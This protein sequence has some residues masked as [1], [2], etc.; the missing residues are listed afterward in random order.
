[1]QQLTE[2]PKFDTLKNRSEVTHEEFQKQK[3]TFASQQVCG[4]VCLPVCQL[5]LEQRMGQTRNNLFS[6]YIS[7]YDSQIADLLLAM[8]SFLCPVGFNQCT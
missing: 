6:R 4:L 8:P 2:S 7:L 3:F 1:M 5:A